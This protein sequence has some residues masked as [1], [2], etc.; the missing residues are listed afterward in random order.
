MWVVGN[1]RKKKAK[2]KKERQVAGV[3]VLGAKPHFQDAVFCPRKQNL[4]RKNYGAF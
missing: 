1:K 3:E 4:F 2:K